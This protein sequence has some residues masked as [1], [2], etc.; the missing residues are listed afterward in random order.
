MSVLSS[1]LVLFDQVSV[2]QPPSVVAQL[3]ISAFLHSND[4]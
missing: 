4:S 3:K 1:A 2:M